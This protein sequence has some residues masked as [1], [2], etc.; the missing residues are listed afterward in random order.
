MALIRS[1]SAISEKWATVTPAR[2]EEYRKGVENPLKE[3]EKETGEAAPAWKQGIQAAV[4][5]SGF[6]KGVKAA[7]QAKWARKTSQVGPTRWGPG[8]SMAKPDFEAGFAPFAEEIARVKLPPKG[9]SGD[10]R[11]YARVES[12]GKAL[13]QK[14]LAMLK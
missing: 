10:P 1:A 11:N 13:H 3:W 8:V 5:R 12:I 4:A 14:K 7:G 2:S 9:P 6:S